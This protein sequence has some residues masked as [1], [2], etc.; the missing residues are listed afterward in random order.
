[1]FGAIKKIWNR[2]R[3]LLIVVAL[4]V[5]GVVTFRRRPLL[6]CRAG[7]SHHYRATRRLY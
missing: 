5:A 4:A 2:H 7:H 3:A 1:M 6:P